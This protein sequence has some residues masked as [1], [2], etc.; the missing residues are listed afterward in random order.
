MPEAKTSISWL[1]TSG[2]AGCDSACSAEGVPGPARRFVGEFLGQDT[3]RLL[4]KAHL[5]ECGALGRTLNVARSRSPGFPDP[6]ASPPAQLAKRS[7]P[8]VRP[9]GAASQLD[10]FEQPKTF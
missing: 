2:V 6:L 4:K 5:R 8:R 7:T 10:L 9:S 1:R 3:S